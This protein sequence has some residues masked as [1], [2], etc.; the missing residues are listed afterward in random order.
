MQLV[1]W[2]S[3][4]NNLKGTSKTSENSRTWKAFDCG[5]CWHSIDEKGPQIVKKN[6]MLH[7][8][9]IIKLTCEEE[10][11]SHE[12]YISFIRIEKSP[13]SRW[14]RNSKANTSSG[15]HRKNQTRGDKKQNKKQKNTHQYE[16]KC[17]SHTC[18]GT[19]NSSMY[20]S[21]LTITTSPL[22][23]I[24]RKKTAVLV[25]DIDLVNFYNVME[26]CKIKSPS[27]CCHKSHCHFTFKSARPL[28]SLAIAKAH[29]AYRETMDL[30]STNL[31]TDWNTLSKL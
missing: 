16:Q 20:D 31:L 4:G 7:Q 2:E 10:L 21:D 1:A 3:T 23:R 12:Y 18:S 6:A 27:G 11:N 17:Q 5:E 13:F 8:D 9:Q 19:I 25:A 26:F 30:E 28:S 24:I 29:V 15:S 14:R 22:T